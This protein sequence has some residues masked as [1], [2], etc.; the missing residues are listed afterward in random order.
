M[1]AEMKRRIFSVQFF[2]NKTKNN[3]N[4][5]KKKE[6]AKKGVKRFN[7]SVAPEFR[8]ELLIEYCLWWIKANLPLPIASENLGIRF[9]EYEC[10]LLF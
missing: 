1:R 2:L 7:G 8:V 9:Y 10:E 6:I 5:N 4:F 3:E